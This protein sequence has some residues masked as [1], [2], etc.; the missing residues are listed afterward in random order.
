MSDKIKITLYNWLS[1]L[2][3]E[4]NQEKIDEFNKDYGADF[5]ELNEDSN[6][7]VETSFLCNDPY[8]FFEPKGKFVSISKWSVYDEDWDNHTIA[9]FIDFENCECPNE[10]K[11]YLTDDSW[12]ITN[13]DKNFLEECDLRNVLLKEL[14]EGEREV[15]NNGDGCIRYSDFDFKDIFEEHIIN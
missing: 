5:G 9:Y 11:K 13:R 6:Y 12:L 2:D 1:S 3:F 4:T 8:V 10:L 15:D 7:E 14:D